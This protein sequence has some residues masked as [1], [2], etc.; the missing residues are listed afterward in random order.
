M[1]HIFQISLFMVALLFSTQTV[2]QNLLNKANKQYEL[3]A[4]KSAIPNFLKLLSNDPDQPQVITQLADSYQNIN[5]TDSALKWYKKGALYAGTSPEHFLNYGKA[6]MTSGEYDEAAKWFKIYSETDKVTG[7]HFM[8]SCDYAISLRGKNSTFRVYKEYLNTNSSDFGPAF[9]GDY[10]VYSSARTDIKRKLKRNQPKGFSG[11]PNN[12]LYI[13]STDNNGYLRTPTLLQSDLQNNYNEGPV[14]FSEDGEWVVFTKNNFE[15]GIRLISSGG[16]DMSLY[17]A[18][19]NAQGVWNNVKA[20]PFNVSGYSNAYP[21]ISADGK[22]IYFASNRKGGFGGWDIYA[23]F[24]TGEGLGWSIPQNLGPIV[25]TQGNEITPFLDN[26][27]LY[28][29]SDF[30]HGLG[31]MDIFRATQR[32]GQWNDIY[33]IGNAINSP[34][35]DYGFIFRGEENRGY[36]V[37]NRNGSLGHEDIYKVS[38]TTDSFIVTVTN[39]SDGRPIEGATIDFTECGESTYSTDINGKHT[40]QALAGLSCNAIIKAE[41]FKPYSLKISSLGEKS[42][43]AYDVKLR[44]H[45]EEYLG[46]IVDSETNEVVTDAVIIATNPSNGLTF[47]T[48]SNQRG[49]YTLALRSPEKYHISYSKAGYVNTHKK[50]RV[51]TQT[52]KSVLGILSFKKSYT[53]TERPAP[54][55]NTSDNVVITK[56]ER[57]VPIEN[58]I[59]SYDQEVPTKKGYAVQVAAYFDDREI[60]VGKYEN[61]QE[62]GNVYKMKDGKA[63]KVRVG[64][65]PTRRD[66]ELAKKTI[67]KKGY[68]K[69]FVVAETDARSVNQLK[70]E[71]DEEN[72]KGG[73]V[74]YDVVV[75]QP[76]T[77]YLLRVATFRSTKNFDQSMIEAFGNV[78]RRKAGKFTIV[79][80]TGFH[81]LEDALMKQSKIQEMGYAD[82]HLVYED[83][84]KLK[85]VR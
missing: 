25:N 44:R 62:Y 39:E 72:E 82:A 37:T 43:L 2:G 27:S 19:V 58:P 68:A 52:D 50:V 4:Y 28:F 10:V 14:S 60:N 35:D 31:G 85:K 71:E 76:K 41:G 26:G 45:G 56:V 59:V 75:E 42:T 7:E 69:A 77:A 13:T 30:H 8:K 84:K 23:S 34:G 67:T 38:K 24:K 12:Q 65:F 3:K 78:E 83:G 51:T 18:E 5:E 81:S 66:A 32:S 48:T 64:I 17:I 57:E 6:L 22:K 21:W 46:K 11:S 61:L 53:L 70:V 47:K 15:N 29:S 73:V 55:G 1:R 63:Q 33:H 40:F 80:L 20:L 36:F 74:Q 16:G 49:E 9:Y 79:L 54:A